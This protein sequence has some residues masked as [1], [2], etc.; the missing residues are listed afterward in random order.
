M[1]QDSG[2][3]GSLAHH[4]CGMMT[5]GSV[6]TIRAKRGDHPSESCGS[7][8]F[9]MGM[10]PST[11]TSQTIAPHPNAPPRQNDGAVAKW[12]SGRRQTWD[13]GCGQGRWERCGG[14]EGGWD[15]RLCSSLVDGM[16]YRWET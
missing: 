12:A 11:K 3:C 6:L 4:S 7:F 2:Q 5:Q 15:R 8:V 10:A 14:Q 16:G 1:L 13:L 9:N